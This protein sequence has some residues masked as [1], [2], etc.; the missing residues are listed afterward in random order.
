MAL[1]PRKV[2]SV[3]ASPCGSKPLVWSKPAGATV[4]PVWLLTFGVRTSE[5]AST[6]AKNVM[7]INLRTFMAPPL[8]D[9]ASGFRQKRGAPAGRPLDARAENWK[10]Q[11][12]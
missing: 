6:E 1:S 9:A 2:S 10:G 4:A 7:A 8:L 12:R 11:I 3:L 5:A